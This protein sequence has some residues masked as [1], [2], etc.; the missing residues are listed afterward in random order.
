MALNLGL[1]KFV[2]VGS[3]SCSHDNDTTR[4]DNAKH[5]HNKL[6]VNDLFNTNI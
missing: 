6:I 5:E 2:R 3:L 4:H 1:T